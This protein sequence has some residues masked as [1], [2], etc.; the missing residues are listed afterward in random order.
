MIPY[1]Q[2]FTS[3]ITVDGTH[4]DVFP[5]ND[6]IDVETVESF[7]EEWSAFHTFNEEEIFSAGDNYFDIVPQSL[8]NKSAHVLDV[9]CGTGRWSYYIAGKVNCVECIDP[10]KAVLAAARLLKNKPN[11]RISQASVDN[12]PFSDNSFDL[13]F[14]LGVLHHVPD[15]KEAVKKCVQKVK[16]N[17][18]ILLYL[19]YNLENRGLA[20]KTLF[21]LSNSIRWIV[22]K[23]PSKLKI[24]VCNLLAIVFYLPFIALAKLLLAAGVSENV[25]SKIPL[26]WYANKSFHIIRN[27]SL[28]RFGTPLEQRFSKQQISG[29]LEHA[30]CTNIVF[31]DNAPYWRV[32]AQKK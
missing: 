16:Q 6:N 26:S 9:G 22:S 8:L 25:V 23:L 17:G 20:F 31:A 12:I 24:A 11:I 19:Y 27:D 4:I 14:S 32:I 7:G 21:H 29:M 1:N 5:S 13:V 10:S 28:D 15:T 18:H 30:G 3:T 2:T